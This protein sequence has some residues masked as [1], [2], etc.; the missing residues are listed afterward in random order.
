MPHPTCR[1]FVAFALLLLTLPALAAEPASNRHLLYVA[2][3]GI[4]AEVKRGGVGVL[5]YDIDDNYKLLRRIPVPAL[6]P[7][8]QALPVKGI[9]ANSTTARLYISSTKGLICLDL[10]TDKVLWERTYEAGCDR[11][12]ISPDGKWIYE[13]TLEGLYW[14]VIDAA[15]GDEIAKIITQSGAH[16]TVYALDGKHVYLAGLKSPLLTVADPATHKASGTVGPF[17]APVRPFTVNGKATLVYVCINELLGFEIG[18]LATGKKLAR[19]EVQGE[20]HG[21]TLRHGCPSHGV[22]LTPDEKELWLCD[23]HNSKLHIFDNTTMPPKQV[24]SISLRDQPGWITF[25]L[26]GRWAF[27]ST[28]EVIDSKARKIVY[29]LRDEQNRDVHS[30]KVMEIDFIGDR[31]VRTGD[32]FGLGRVTAQ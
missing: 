14:H 7:E 20:E 24:A 6:G 3:P 15:N 13:P 21:P 16:N 4:R 2:L 10:T 29:S 8:T 23:G 27:S 5:V 18:D 30:E 11:M 22:A 9:C 32:Q 19:V 25:S 26:D 28:G 17:A 1:I 31:P 12:S